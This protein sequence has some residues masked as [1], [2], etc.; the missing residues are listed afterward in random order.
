MAISFKM[1]GAFVEDRIGND[2]NSRLVVTPKSD[3]ES[4]GKSK[5]LIKENTS[6]NL[7]CNRQRKESK[8]NDFEILHKKY[9]LI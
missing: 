5:I 8:L 4:S 3:R 7:I 6:L 9:L 2:R 1:F